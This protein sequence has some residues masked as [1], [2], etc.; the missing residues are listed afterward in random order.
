[1]VRIGPLPS[2]QTTLQKSVSVTDQAT[3][4]LSALIVWFVSVIGN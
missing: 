3:V 1:M 2:P 4:K